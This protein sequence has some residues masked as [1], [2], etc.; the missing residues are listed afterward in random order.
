MAEYHHDFWTV[1]ATVSPLLAL[2]VVVLINR[3]R[4]TTLQGAARKRAKELSAT[5]PEAEKAVRRVRTLGYLLQVTAWVS[6]G[7][8]ATVTIIAMWSLAAR[9][10]H[11]VWNPHV[12]IFFMIASGA[13]LPTSTQIENYFLD[14][15][16][17]A[18]LKPSDYDPRYDDR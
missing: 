18:G 7:L 5:G 8:S 17:T 15:A 14:A 3:Y 10:P 13:L 16:K 4:V 9:T 12:A 1:A 2:A 6:F 11:D